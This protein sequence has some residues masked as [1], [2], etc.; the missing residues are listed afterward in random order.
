MHLDEQQ[1]SY[2]VNEKALIV[3]FLISPTLINNIFSL[4]A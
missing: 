4:N 1:T 3:S 2:S